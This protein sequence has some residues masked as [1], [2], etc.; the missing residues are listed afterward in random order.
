MRPKRETVKFAKRVGQK[1]FLNGFFLKH[2]IATVS[3]FGGLLEMLDGNP[4]RFTQIINY[5]GTTVD[6]L[7]IFIKGQMTS[8]REACRMNHGTIGASFR[9]VPAEALGRVKRLVAQMERIGLGGVLAIGRPNQPLLQVPVQQG[10]AGLVV[11][12]GLN[13]LAAVEESGIPTTNIALHTL[14]EFEGL[15][16]YTVLKEFQWTDEGHG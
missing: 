4:Y 15:T 3:R 5:D 11:A 8:V 13:P 16:P 9:E 12:G 6:P 1:Y 14:F 10:R 7:E 2:G